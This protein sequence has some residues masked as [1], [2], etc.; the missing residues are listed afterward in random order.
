MHYLD[1]YDS[2]L[3]RKDEQNIENKITKK[4][5]NKLKY[6]W[7]DLCLEENFKG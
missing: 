1:E 5:K 2:H 7:D 3:T 6:E 4:I